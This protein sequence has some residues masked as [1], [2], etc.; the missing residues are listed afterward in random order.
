MPPRQNG[1]FFGPMICRSVFFGFFIVDKKEKI[2]YRL[3]TMTAVISPSSS[4]KLTRQDLAKLNQDQ[5]TEEN[6]AELKSRGGV[7]GL[8]SL[9]DVDLKCGLTGEEESSGWASRRAA[10]GSNVYPSP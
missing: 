9:L 10:Y 6:K 4:L 7:E 3:V 2:F 5:M 8:A 1:V